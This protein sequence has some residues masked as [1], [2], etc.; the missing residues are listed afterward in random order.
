VLPPVPAFCD[1]AL[2]VQ[3]CEAFIFLHFRASDYFMGMKIF[4]IFCTIMHY[5]GEQNKAMDKTDGQE[6]ER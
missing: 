5:T 4:A 2:T 3:R 1:P 6:Q